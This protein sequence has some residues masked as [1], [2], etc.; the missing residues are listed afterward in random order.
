MKVLL[1]VNWPNLPIRSFGFFFGERVEMKKIFRYLAVSIWIVQMLILCQNTALA[2]PM[3]LDSG[4]SLRPYIE[5]GGVIGTDP[6]DVSQTGTINPLNASA[7]A[8]VYDGK[9]SARTSIEVSSQWTEISA[10]TVAFN[11]QIYF[12]NFPDGAAAEGDFLSTGDPTLWSYEFIPDTN[13]LFT[14][15]WDTWF[16]LKSHLSGLTLG[17]GPA[18]FNYIVNG[19]G[20]QNIS[21]V[22]NQTFLMSSGDAFKID[23]GWSG[24]SPGMSGT[25][26]QVID[27]DGTFNWN[28]ET[29]GT[30]VPI[31]TAVLLLGS[32]LIGCVGLRRKIK[33]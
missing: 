10:G 26:P 21:G 7:F 11:G 18:S 31:P 22:G 17:E 6:Q 13:G 2:S 15:E 27:Y 33:D 9:Y 5:M 24:T 28:F 4:I 8:I 19:G 12:D 23:I 30:P 14:L 3:A 16:T 29:S 32:G 20:Y 25:A 1:N